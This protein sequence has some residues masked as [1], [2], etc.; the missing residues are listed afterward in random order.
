MKKLKWLGIFEKKKIGIKNA[1]PAQ[2]LLHI[3]EQ[4]WQLDP[5]DKDMIV[6]KHEFQ[7][8]ENNIKKQMSSSLVVRGIDNTHTAMSI[9]VGMPIAIVTKLLLNNKISVRG[10]QLPIVKEIYE[11]VLEELKEHGV[12]FIE[13]G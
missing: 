3:L 4:K 2:I 9:T 6:M 5:E 13:K 10:V 12:R 1:T 8:E 7:Y 11:P